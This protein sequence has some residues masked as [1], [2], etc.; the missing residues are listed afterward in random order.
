MTLTIPDLNLRLIAPALIV[1]IS[2]IIVLLGEIF[3]P[4]NQKRWIGY[5]ALVGLAIAGEAALSMWGATTT[6]F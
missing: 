2:A 1:A 3:T 6:G 5:A 4:A